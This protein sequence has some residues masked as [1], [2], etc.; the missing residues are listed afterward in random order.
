MKR[1]YGIDLLRMV[2]MF[3]VV[4]IHVLERGG[5]LAAAEPMTVKYGLSWLIKSFVYCAVNCYALI[6]GYVHF[7]GRYRFSSLLQIWLQALIYSLGIAV[8]GW[9]LKPDLISVRSITFFLFPIS[10]RGYWYLSAYVGLF[11]LIPF[12]HAGINSLSKN[13]MKTYLGL[14]FAA[15][16][17]IPTFACQ[18]TFMLNAGFSVIWLAFMYVIGACIR[19]YDW[20]GNLKPEKTAMIYIASVLVSWVIRMYFGGISNRLSGEPVTGPDFIAYVSPT[21][22]IGA[23]ALF[24]TFKKAGVPS[25]LTGFISRFSPAA[26]GVYLIHEHEYIKGPFMTDRFSFLTEFSAPVMVFG[27]LLSAFAVFAVCLLADFVR[28]NVFKWLKVKER[29]E[30]LEEKYFHHILAVTE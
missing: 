26:F 25:R 17:V 1:N 30:R 10:K 2:L 6:S 13:Q 9:I 22:V 28:V 8:C 21:V 7:G 23:V 11:L 14:L 4:V 29:L 27:I 16:T 3:M 19:K 20:W 12:I 24:L 5:V 15:F 18:D